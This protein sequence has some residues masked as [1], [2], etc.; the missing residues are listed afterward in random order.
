MDWIR[1]ITEDE[2]H[3]VQDVYETCL[4]YQMMD[5][6]NDIY[7]YN[8]YSDLQ[9]HIQSSNIDELEQFIEVLGQELFP[10]WTRRSIV[11]V[12]IIVAP[13]EMTGNQPWH[14]D[15]TGRE[16]HC[17][18]PLTPLTLLNS[19]QFIRKKWTDDELQK[20]QSASFPDLERLMQCV[21]TSTINV[22]QVV[23]KEYSILRMQPG[24]VHRG[25]MNQGTRERV[26]LC[27]VFNDDHI[28][29]NEPV[30]TTF[31]QIQ[32]NTS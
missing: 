5:K 11:S 12:C 24:T 16:G 18:I 3:I 27:I 25:V 29:I 15:Y 7:W 14:I 26:M 30:I 4:A 13:L 28:V 17:F 23:C 32:L 8:V 6:V 10:Q 21:N 1:H 22:E 31:D 20:L 19:T 9:Y 2:Q